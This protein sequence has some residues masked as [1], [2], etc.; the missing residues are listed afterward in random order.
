MASTSGIKAHN[1]N[2]QPMQGEIQASSFHIEVLIKYTV[3]I[4]AF[5][6]LARAW[7]QGQHRCVESERMYLQLVGHMPSR[8][9]RECILGNK[10][11]L[12]D[13]KNMQLLRLQEVIS[14]ARL[15]TRHIIMI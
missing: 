3:N 1:H 15:D 2:F 12:F 14:K 5:S 10:E 11:Q 13:I 4:P 7:L 9:S 6:P 8:R